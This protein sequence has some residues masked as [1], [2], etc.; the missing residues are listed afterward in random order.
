MEPSNLDVMRQLGVEPTTRRYLVLKSRAH[1]QDS[2]G[3]GAIYKG[4]VGCD[5]LGVCGSD[6][7]ALSFRNHGMCGVV[8]SRSMTSELCVEVPPS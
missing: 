6:Y 3:F 7:G 2:S 8:S 5:G 1:W 4:V